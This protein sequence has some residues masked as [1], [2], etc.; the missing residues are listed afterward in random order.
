MPVFSKVMY[1]EQGAYEYRNG[2]RI[3][4]KIS[5]PGPDQK[6]RR[7]CKDTF[8]MVPL[9]WAAKMT[10]AT[11]T[12]KAMVGVWLLYRAWQKKSPT[13][14]VPNE[15]LAAFGISRKVKYRAL[16]QF[17]A[18]GL[19]KVERRHRKTLRVTLLGL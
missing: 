15:A 3:N 11:E 9:Q 4:I 14:D 2:K 18:A 7:R 19:I 5:E 1:D 10:A 6:I 16:E 12:P 17:E 8:A 13:F